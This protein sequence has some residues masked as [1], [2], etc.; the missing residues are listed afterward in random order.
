M[1]SVLEGLRGYIQLASGL[2]DVTRA[3]ARE[4]AKALLA[5]GEAGVESVVP[6]PVRAQV[7]SLADDLLATSKANRDLL[8][9]L[10]RTEV[11]RSVARMGLVSSRDLEAASKRARH[12]EL[13]VAQLEQELSL[14]RSAATKRTTAEKSTTRKSAAKKSAAKK[15]AA[16][17]TSSATTAPSGAAVGGGTP[18]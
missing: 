9:N 5:Q 1:S 3:R 4:A 12:L 16:A 13:R 10:V 17:K 8:V 18:S 6:Q 15:S 7:G 2:T 14:A 11:D